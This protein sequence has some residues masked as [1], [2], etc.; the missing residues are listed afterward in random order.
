M[1]IPWLGGERGR[2]GLWGRIPTV[3]A[4]MEPDELERLVIFGRSRLYRAAAE[5]DPEL[6]QVA[7]GLLLSVGEPVDPAPLLEP[8]GIL[9]ELS[10]LGRA[11]A[12]PRGRA[13]AQ[14]R[15]DPAQTAFLATVFRAV[16]LDARRV[17]MPG[18]LF[19]PTASGRDT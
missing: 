4:L 6:E 16:L 19:L 11:L 13:R 15:L 1:I 12:V 8:A 14:D 2:A 18:L 5:Q 3:S 17:V 10:R 7:R 9:T